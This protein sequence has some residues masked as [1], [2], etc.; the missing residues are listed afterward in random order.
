MLIFRNC[1]DLFFFFGGDVLFPMSLLELVAWS[2]RLRCFLGIYYLADHDPCVDTIF[3][4][5]MFFIS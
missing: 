3:Q 5:L 4:S 2:A 1:I